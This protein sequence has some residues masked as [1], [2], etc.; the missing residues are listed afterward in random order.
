MTQYINNFSQKC[1]FGKTFSLL[2]LFLIGLILTSGIA[3]GQSHQV[4]FEQ[5][6]TLKATDLLGADLMKSSLY[7]VDEDVVN[8]GLFECGKGRNQVSFHLPFTFTYVSSTCQLSPSPAP[9]NQRIRFSI[10]GAYC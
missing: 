4:Q 7:T 9:L 3:C 8:D 2:L 1:E 5:T 6:V 10:S